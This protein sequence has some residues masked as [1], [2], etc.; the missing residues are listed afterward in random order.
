M[1]VS[2]PSNDSML[3]MEDGES[4]DQQGRCQTSSPSD[5]MTIGFVQSEPSSSDSKPNNKCKSKKEESSDNAAGG[6]VPFFIMD[7]LERVDP[8][9]MELAQRLL[10]TPP[11]KEGNNNS[12]KFKI[13]LLDLANSP[14]TPGPDDESSPNK[15][16]RNG[17]SNSSQ[18]NNLKPIRKDL[19]QTFQQRSTA[20][21]NG[22]N[23]RGILKA[24]Q[25]R[26]EDALACWENALEIRIQ[27]AKASSS[28]H[29]STNSDSK[30]NEPNQHLL[31]VANTRN[32]IGIALGK[33]DRIDE[34]VE[35]LQTAL[36]I[37]QEQY[38]TSGGHPE[39]AATLHNLGNVYQQD[40][41]YRQAIDYF[42]RCREWQERRH[43]T[44]HHADVA[45][46]CLALGH[47]YHQAG[48]FHDARAA[49]HDALQIFAR[50]GLPPD[51]PEVAAT[52]E[53]VRELHQE[54]QQQEQEAE[55]QQ[56]YW[57]SQEE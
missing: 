8:Q 38:G 35:S 6:G 29:N 28:Y 54:E 2:I 49:Y 37:R 18:D 46:A 36:E 31:D 51:D 17:N 11:S 16:A 5:V 53:D 42:A 43:G 55:Q 48:A 25:G 40:G 15:S 23:A 1:F 56:Q 9:A 13:N 33:L 19:F 21:G 47:T 24:R 12:N 44:A 30:K 4:K 27:I 39:I 3:D 20:I 22:Y 50:L 41:D 7:W 14:K 26:W 32:N 52:L 10:Q 45:R 57:L 34:A